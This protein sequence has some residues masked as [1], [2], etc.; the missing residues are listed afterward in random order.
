MTRGGNGG[1]SFGDA[2]K[3]TEGTKFTATLPKCKIKDI[4][5]KNARVTCVL[6]TDQTGGSTSGLDWV[7]D[8]R[9][10]KGERKKGHQKSTAGEPPNRGVPRPTGTRKKKGS[11]EKRKESR[12]V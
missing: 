7:R 10:G 1:P 4:S 11:R 5:V 12:P 2:L 9:S 3:L 8:K 6:P